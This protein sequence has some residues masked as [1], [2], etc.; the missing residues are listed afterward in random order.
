MAFIINLFFRAE[1]FLKQTAGDEKVQESHNL[2]MFLATHD[3]ITTK[4]KSSL[5]E[6]EGYDDLFA[7]IIQL[8]CY[9]Y[10]F[11]MYIL[12]RE[13]HLLLKVRFFSSV[14][15]VYSKLTQKIREDK[16]S[17]IFVTFFVRFELFFVR[18]G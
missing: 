1:T 10:E 6:I 17:Y 8:A 13:K 3:I 11:K 18:T 15:K 9:F 4:L 2:T 16:S 14:V 12:P 7:D 5:E